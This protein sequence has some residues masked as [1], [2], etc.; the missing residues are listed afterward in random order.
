MVISREKKDAY[1]QEIYEEMRRR[2][3]QADEIPRVIGK[4]G[5]MTALEKYPEEQLHYEISDAVD[6][7]ITT[8]ARF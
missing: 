3:F 7:I 2:G 6:E 1:L 5:F 8:A 4:T